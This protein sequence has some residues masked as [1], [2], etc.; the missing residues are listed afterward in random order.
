MFQQAVDRISDHAPTATYVG[1][2][3]TFLGAGLHLSDVCIIIT[4]TI[5]VCGFLLQCY[6]AFR[7]IRY[8]N[9]QREDLS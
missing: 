7:K 1:A 5:A 6:L 3:G 4:T 2:G 8:Y 9:K